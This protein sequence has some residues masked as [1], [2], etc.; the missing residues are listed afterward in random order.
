MPK[1]YCIGSPVWNGASKVLEEAA[2]VSVELA[3]LINNEGQR[4][5]WGGVDLIQ[6]IQEEVGDLYAS[7]DY[8]LENNPQLDKRFIADRRSRKYATYTAWNEENIS[9]GKVSDRNKK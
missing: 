7:L 6:N 5:Y 4:E 2:E 8:F 9:M 3:K 1:D